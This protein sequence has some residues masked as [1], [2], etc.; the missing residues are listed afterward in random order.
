MKP[1]VSVLIPVYGVEN[2]IEKCLKSL[3]ENTLAEKCEFILVNDCTKDNS[4][5]IACSIMEK[6]PKLNVRIINHEKNKGLAAARNTGL[7][8]AIGKYIICCDSDDWVEKNY[9]EKLY[10]KAESESADVVGCDCYEERPHEQRRF[11]HNL[12]TDD[13]DK[14]FEDFLKCKIFAYVWSKMVK[15]DLFE[16]N[17]LAWEEGIN[18]WEDEI[19]STKIFSVAKKIAYVP[20]PLYHYLFREDSYIHIIINEKTK[21]DFI[22]SVAAMEKYLDNEKFLKYKNLVNYKKIHAKQ[23]ILIDGTYQMQKKYLSLW[24]ECYPYIKQDKTLALRTRI[25][26]ETSEK[27]PFV[28]LILLRTLSTLKVVIKKQFTWKQYFQNDK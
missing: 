16:K 28:S 17:N 19:I 6:Y 3:F 15:R 11:F 14:N 2:Y 21:N 25:I 1:L 26:L 13:S 23:K 22:N 5:K 27:V 10:E 12:I 4:I 9:L 24:P 18:N 20:E 8:N 7:K